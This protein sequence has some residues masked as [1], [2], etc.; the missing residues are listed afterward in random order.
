MTQPSE[1]EPR[2]FTFDEIKTNITPV[3]PG[4][5]ITG[6]ETLEHLDVCVLALARRTF[7]SILCQDFP[8]RVSDPASA[9][10]KTRSAFRGWNNSR[11]PSEIMKPKKF[12]GKFVDIS[13]TN[14]GEQ[15]PREVDSSGSMRWPLT[16][17]L[18]ANMRSTGRGV[19]GRVSKIAT[20][21]MRFPHDS[22]KDTHIG[23][24]N[25]PDD[26]AKTA[27]RML[28]AESSAIAGIVQS[29]N[30]RN[31]ILSGLPSLGQ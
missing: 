11:M 19:V 17:L 27:A 13:L 22:V 18:S 21:S 30:L 2:V 9:G 1:R 31:V 24:Q 23:Y 4:D 16:L 25:L 26:T 7:N 15:Q 5:H 8:A 12:Y 10:T 29:G 20:G 28:G 14:L 3:Q 6:F